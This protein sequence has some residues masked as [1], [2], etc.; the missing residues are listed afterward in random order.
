VIDGLKDQLAVIE[1]ELSQLL[2]EEQAL[3]EPPKEG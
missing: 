1:A 3:T 2:K